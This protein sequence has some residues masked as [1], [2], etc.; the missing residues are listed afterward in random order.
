MPDIMEIGKAIVSLCDQQEYMEAI[1]R[2][3]ADD[4]VSVEASAGPDMP[5]RTEGIEAI[6]GKT[7]WWVE[8]HT[9]HSTEAKGPYPHGDRFILFFKLDVT[10][11]AGPMSGQR[12]QMEEAAL[13][14]VKNGKIVH[15]EFF[16][17][18]G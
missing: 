11:K 10:A 2:F 4:I 18:M 1:E 16:Y 12:F 8:N 13:Y 15:E 7:R 5:A 3:Y 17:S 14:T 6:K 9:V